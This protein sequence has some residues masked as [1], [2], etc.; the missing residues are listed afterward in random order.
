MLNGFPY[1]IGGYDGRVVHRSVERFDSATRTWSPVADMSIGRQSAGIFLF[2][3]KYFFQTLN[4]FLFR[5]VLLRTK[6]YFTLSEVATV[7]QS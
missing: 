4:C 5:K 2:C 6:A 1:V 3:P 7:T